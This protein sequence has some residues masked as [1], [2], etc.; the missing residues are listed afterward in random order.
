MSRGFSCVFR[1][2]YRQ[3]SDNIQYEKA[4]KFS[5][6]FSFSSGPCS[7]QAQLSLDFRIGKIF[8]LYACIFYINQ[9]FFC[10]LENGENLTRTAGHLSSI[11]GQIS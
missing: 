1:I 3:F 7:P 2:F 6:P 9:L 11:E 5:G 4:R 10:I 8:S